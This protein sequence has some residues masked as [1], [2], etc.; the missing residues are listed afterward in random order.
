M[1]MYLNLFIQ[2]RFFNDSNADNKKPQEA[3][4]EPQRR[5]RVRVTDRVDEEKLP[6]SVQHQLQA[7]KNAIMAKRPAAAQFARRGAPRR[8]SKRWMPEEDQLL[9]LMRDNGFGYNQIEEFFT[10]RN[11]NPLEKRV[12]KL[13]DD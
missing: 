6:N 7:L 12:S 8:T 3:E 2:A 13:L 11:R 5:A 4:D 1:M 9:L 10:W